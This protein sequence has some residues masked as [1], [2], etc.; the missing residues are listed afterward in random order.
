MSKLND[1]VVNTK[2]NKSK[3]SLLI[4]IFLSLIISNVFS[5]H[6]YWDDGK[7]NLQELLNMYQTKY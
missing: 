1:K 7:M 4:V 3:C 5:Q 6:S 2:Y